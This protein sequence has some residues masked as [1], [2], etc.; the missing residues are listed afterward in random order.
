[1]SEIDTIENPPGSS[2]EAAASDASS[3]MSAGRGAL[4]RVQHLLHRYPVVSPAL[5]LLVSALVFTYF[6]NGRFQEP[7]TIGIMLQQTAV[8][9]TLAIGQTLIILTAGIDLSIGTAML[10][11]HL[12]MARMAVFGATVPMV[13]WVID[14]IH[15]ILALLL[16]LMLGLLLGAIHGGFVTRLGLP[17]FIVTLGTFYIYNS[18]A[19]VYSKAQTTSKEDIGPD[20]LLLWLGDRFSIGS[21]AITTGVLLTL[22]LFAVFAFIL[23]NTAWGRHVYATG[24]DAE[25]ARLAGINTTRVIIS[26][27][28][29][30]GLVYAIGGWVQLGRSLSASNNAATDINLET[31]TAVV[32]GGTSLFGGRGR[33]V[34]TLI[35]AMI[36]TMF[37]TGLSLAGV[38]AF[39]KNFAI[40]MLILFAVAL[41]TWIRRVGA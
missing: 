3:L 15:P 14:P 38:D 33:L 22:V 5:V 25:A 24:D 18:L 12:V 6:G 36:V 21:M 9:A 34:G 23:S 31:I 1:M 7:S 10:L 40:G 28:M 27:Y 26:V 8:L 20:S 16:G 30:A 19:N 35:G 37:D 11:V 41:D 13:G 2:D 39:Y 29:V 17:P 4:D 32:I